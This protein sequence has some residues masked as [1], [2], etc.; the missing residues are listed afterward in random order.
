MYNIYTYIRG[1]WPKWKGKGIRGKDGE[2]GR[3]EEE[4]CNKDATKYE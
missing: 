3:E 1:I 2:G 4:Y